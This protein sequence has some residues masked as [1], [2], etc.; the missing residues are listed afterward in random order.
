M[1]SPILMTWDQR[2]IYSGL[3][4]RTQGYGDRLFYLA[5]KFGKWHFASGLSL[6][7]FPR[8]SLSDKALRRFY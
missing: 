7:R 3:P 8:F 2:S 6:R 5:L 1:Q 4:K